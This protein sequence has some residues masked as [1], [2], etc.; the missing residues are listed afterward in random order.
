MVKLILVIAPLHTGECTLSLQTLHSLHVFS[1][2]RSRWFA[3]NCLISGCGG[4]G[5]GG[6]GPWFITFVA[7]HGVNAH[8]MLSFKLAV[9]SH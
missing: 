5:R 9:C 3:S 7:F 1:F 2:K 8:T 4:G 6:E